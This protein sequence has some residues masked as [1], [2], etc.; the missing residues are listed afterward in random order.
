MPRPV[1]C[2]ER[3][4]V[5]LATKGETTTH[6]RWPKEVVEAWL[7]ADVLSFADERQRRAARR[8][9]RRARWRVRRVRQRQF[10]P[11]AF[12]APLAAVFSRRPS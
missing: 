2:E 1:T 12:T 4:D 9:V 10:L 5:E 7:A 8:R 11:A 3:L 6:R